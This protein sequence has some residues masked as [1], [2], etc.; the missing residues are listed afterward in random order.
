LLNLKKKITFYKPGC[1]NDISQYTGTLYDYAKKM[2]NKVAESLLCQ[3]NDGIGLQ[4]RVV[5]LCILTPPQ[6]N[7]DPAVIELQQIIK[8]D[9]IENKETFEIAS[10]WI[11]ENSKALNGQ[12]LGHCKG[13]AMYIVVRHYQIERYFPLGLWAELAPAI[14]RNDV[15]KVK[16]LSNCKDFLAHPYSLLAMNRRKKIYTRI[17]PELRE[18]S[19]RVL[20]LLHGAHET[21]RMLYG[22]ENS[23]QALRELNM[24]WFR[25]DFTL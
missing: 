21:A 20:A 16:E 24:L 4:Q 18:A 2:K 11:N 9:S 22:N 19:S 3:L 6:L 17:G 8:R 23:V 13:K 10:K 7:L 5:E 1:G 25:E 14:R 15:A 12:I